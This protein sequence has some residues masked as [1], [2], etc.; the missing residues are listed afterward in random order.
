MGRSGWMGPGESHS[1]MGSGKPQASNTAR[2]N[3]ELEVPTHPKV[4]VTHQ[5]APHLRSWC[6]AHSRH[7]P[8]MLTQW[9]CSQIPAPD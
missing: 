5:A 8:A 1:A 9:R 4:L 7:S 2:S 6:Q 3:R